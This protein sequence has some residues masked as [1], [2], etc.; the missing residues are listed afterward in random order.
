MR[1]LSSPVPGVAL[2]TRAALFCGVQFVLGEGAVMSGTTS[3]NSSPAWQGCRRS[4]NDGEASTRCG[5]S[6]SS[7]YLRCR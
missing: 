7:R 4:G 1:P 2:V 3:G 6:R 5:R